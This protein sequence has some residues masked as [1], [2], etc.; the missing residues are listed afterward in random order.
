MDNKTNCFEL[1][2][3]S[4]LKGYPSAVNRQERLKIMRLNDSVGT[5]CSMRMFHS[6]LPMQTRF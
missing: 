5:N 1:L 3:G 4:K 2:D 6:F